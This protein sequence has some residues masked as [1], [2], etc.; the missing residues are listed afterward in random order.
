MSKRQD[1]RTDYLEKVYYPKRF[2]STVNRA[3]KKIREY[4][5]K[6]KFDA[7]A[8]TG[9]SGAAL[10]YT[11]S[12]KLG[13]PL[14]CVRKSADGHHSMYKVEGCYSAKKYIIIDDF[15]SGGYT[16]K[17][18]IR[19]IKKELENAEPLAVFLYNDQF[20]YGLHDDLPIIR[21]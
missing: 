20:R 2:I 9:T 21:I 15:I 11:V 5:R 17:K 16:V 4:R 8:F 14:I 6:N 13:L 3:V 18:I 1:I 10:A 12:Y 7:I 19:S